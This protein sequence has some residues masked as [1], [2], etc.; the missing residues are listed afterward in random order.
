MIRCSA[1]APLSGLVIVIIFVVTSA[2]ISLVLRLRSVVEPGR[3]VSPSVCLVT[4][5][6]GIPTLRL[7]TAARVSSII[8]A[9]ILAVTSA[10]V[11]I[12]G[13]PAGVVATADFVATEGVFQ[14]EPASKSDI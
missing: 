10:S 12:V 4:V 7:A 1:G 8:I 9:V 2:V 14:S 3:R 5:G 6:A 11:P 13:I